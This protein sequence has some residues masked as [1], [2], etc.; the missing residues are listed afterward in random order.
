[1]HGALAR[2]RCDMRH[3]RTFVELEK[4]GLISAR[5]RYSTGCGDARSFSACQ[6]RIVDDPA[7]RR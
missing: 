2:W 6:R 3:Q 4:S 5:L 7:L 1:M